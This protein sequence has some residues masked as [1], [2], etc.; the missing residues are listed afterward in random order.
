M[1]HAARG[2][3]RWLKISKFFSLLRGL[4]GVP[5][6]KAPPARIAALAAS[7]R[8]AATAATLTSATA[9]ATGQ[10]H[11]AFFLDIAVFGDPVLAP[12]I[13]PEPGCR[14]G[15]FIC[16]RLNSKTVFRAWI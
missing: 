1:L 9:P 8:W 12:T 16:C 13:K 4:S 10:G 14:F 7:G 6:V 3:R 11:N 15:L 2:G 5:K